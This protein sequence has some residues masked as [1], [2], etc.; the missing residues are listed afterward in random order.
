MWGAGGTGSP[1]QRI[2]QAF[3]TGKGTTVA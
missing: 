3:N 1:P 2:A